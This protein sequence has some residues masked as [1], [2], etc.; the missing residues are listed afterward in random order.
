MIIAFGNKTLTP[1]ERR[2]CQTEKEALTLVWAV[3][4]FHMFLYGKEFE[5]VTDHKPLEVIFGPKSKPCA[6][7]ER[8]VLRLQSYKF[9]VNTKYSGADHTSSCIFA[10]NYG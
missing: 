2:Y 3:E 10:R 6:R 8:W 5:L 9:K 7:I 1:C 4:H